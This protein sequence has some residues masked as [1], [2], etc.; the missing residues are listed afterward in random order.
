MDALLS[1]GADP[2]AADS[3]GETALIRAASCRYAQSA[4]RLLRSGADPNARNE[5]GQ[6]ALILAPS[7]PVIVP[8]LLAAGTEVNAQDTNGVSALMEAVRWGRIDKARILIG[9]GADL[10]LKDRSGRTPLH[11]AVEYGWDRQTFLDHT[12]RKAGM[13][14]GCWQQPDTIISTFSAEVFGEDDY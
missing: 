1:A 9:A 3:G 11:V 14:P 5:R 8:A 6:T 2:N 7:D 12:C 4:L 10:H 13:E